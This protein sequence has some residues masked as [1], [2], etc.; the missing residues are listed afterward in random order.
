MKGLQFCGIFMRSRRKRS[1]PLERIVWLY[2]LHWVASPFL[3]CHQRGCIDVFVVGLWGLVDIRQI[4][5]L[6]R[7]FKAVF[8][9]FILHITVLGERYRIGI[10]VVK[11]THKSPNFWGPWKLFFS[12][13]L[14]VASYPPPHPPYRC[15]VWKVATQNRGTGVN[16]QAFETL[17][18]I[19]Y[20]SSV[21][22]VSTR[23]GGG[24]YQLWNFSKP[25]FSKVS[26]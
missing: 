8:P 11:S 25:A 2:H 1:I 15:F 13:R 14:F 12:P 18:N 3:C 16:F 17:K 6:E 7:P 19:T 26:M 4:S 22:K 23:N 5:W 21:R 20:C 10:G 24:W 9:P